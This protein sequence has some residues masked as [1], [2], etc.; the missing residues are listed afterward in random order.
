MNVTFLWTIFKLPMQSF[1]R[2]SKNLGGFWSTIIIS[3]GEICWLLI[4]LISS[5]N[6]FVLPYVHTTS[7]RSAAPAGFFDV[8]V[9]GPK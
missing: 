1:I 5:D 9:S 8:L 2:L 4:E 6:C 3:F 7:D